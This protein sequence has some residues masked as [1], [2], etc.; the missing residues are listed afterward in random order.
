MKTTTTINSNALKSI[1]NFAKRNYQI[2]LNQY[3]LKCLKPI[4]LDEFLKNYSY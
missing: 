2:Y 1:T 3:E 4:T